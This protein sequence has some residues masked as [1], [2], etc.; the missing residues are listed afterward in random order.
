MTPACHRPMTWNATGAPGDGSNAFHVLLQLGWS[1]L[2]QRRGSPGIL[3]YE[4]LQIC[5]FINIIS[6]ITHGYPSYKAT[7][8]LRGPHLQG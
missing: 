6:T 1:Q 2:R 7:Y 5:H 4:L 3:S 8:L